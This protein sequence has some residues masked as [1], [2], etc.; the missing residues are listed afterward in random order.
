MRVARLAQW[1]FLSPAV[2]RLSLAA[3]SCSWLLTATRSCSTLRAP[4]V[5]TPAGLAT[6]SHRPAG[7]NTSPMPRFALRG[8]TRGRDFLPAA[9]RNALPGHRRA[10]ASVLSRLCIGFPRA[11]GARSSRFTNAPCRRQ[12]TQVRAAGDVEKKKY[13][14]RDEAPTARRWRLDIATLTPR[15]FRAG[16]SALIYF[17]KTA[18]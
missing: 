3:R 14:R 17:S 1:G 5:A 18:G 10:G 9:C 8:H 7:R 4:P 16:S 6:C 13:R 2:A 15:Y 12:P 11:G